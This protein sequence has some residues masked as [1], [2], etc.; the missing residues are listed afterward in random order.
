MLVVLNGVCVVKLDIFLNGGFYIDNCIWIVISKMMCV[1]DVGKI[2][3][4][5]CFGDSGGLFQCKN[6][7]D[8]WVVQGIVSWGDF[9]CLLSNYYI[10]FIRVSVFCKWVDDVLESIRSM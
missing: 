9:D 3:I 8:Q 4:Y 6:L 2:K 1:G 7:V 10:V 5:G